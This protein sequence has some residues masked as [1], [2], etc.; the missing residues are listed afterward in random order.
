MLLSFTE[1]NLFWPVTTRHDTCITLFKPLGRIFSRHSAAAFVEFFDAFRH[2]P[3]ADFNKTLCATAT[4]NKKSLI[5][6]MLKDEIGKYAADTFYSL[7]VLAFENDGQLALNFGWMIDYAMHLYGEDTI[8]MAE[9]G[10][11]RGVCGRKGAMQNTP[12]MSLGVN[13]CFACD[14]LTASGEHVIQLDI[15]DS[16]DTHVKPRNTVYL[17][18]FPHIEAKQTSATLSGKSTEQVVHHAVKCFGSHSCKEA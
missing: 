8:L 12:S 9:F 16:N 5:D 13:T 18:V 15:Y 11:G 6:D 2:K 14:P 1:S 4:R 17:A 7:S 3:F 10:R